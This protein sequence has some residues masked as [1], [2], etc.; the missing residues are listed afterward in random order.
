MNE[1]SGVNAQANMGRLFILSNS[2]VV[3]FNM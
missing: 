2:L 3:V 1:S